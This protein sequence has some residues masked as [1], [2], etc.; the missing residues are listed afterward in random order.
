VLHHCIG[1]GVVAEEGADGVLWGVT[2]E[3]V[4]HAMRGEQTLNWNRVVGGGYAA[5]RLRRRCSLEE[6]VSGIEDKESR[7]LKAIAYLI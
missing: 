5:S 2:E 6:D 1:K 3:E 4:E 7:R